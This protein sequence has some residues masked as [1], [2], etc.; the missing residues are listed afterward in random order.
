M[1]DEYVD[2]VRQSF[3]TE[4]VVLL[5]SYCPP[6]AIGPIAAPALFRRHPRGDLWLPGV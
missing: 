5:V 3:E 2:S 6:A 4:T 1:S